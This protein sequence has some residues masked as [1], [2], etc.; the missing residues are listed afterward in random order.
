MRELEET[1]TDELQ[2]AAEGEE[3][4]F[5]EAS[6]K[7]ITEEE[8]L[9]LGNSRRSSTMKASSAAGKYSGEGSMEGE[10]G[11]EGRIEVNYI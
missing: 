4:E 3:E 7:T 5:V 2:S 11:R 1:T 8:S 6:G 9:S 10:K